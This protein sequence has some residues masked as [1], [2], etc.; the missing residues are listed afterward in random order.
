MLFQTYVFSFLYELSLQL[1]VLLYFFA[2]F[3]LGQLYITQS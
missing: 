1:S 3:V 2:M